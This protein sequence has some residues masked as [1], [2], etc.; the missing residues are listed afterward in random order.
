MWILQRL[1]SALSYLHYLGIIHC[2]IKPAN[3]ILHTQEHNA[4]L[5]DFGLCVLDPTADTL[6]K[7]GT[8]FYVPP[9]FVLGLPPIPASD[10]YSLGKTA[11]FLA[12]GD[13]RT[14]TAPADM[15]DPLRKLL[16]SMTLQDSLARPGDARKLHQQLTDIRRQV[17]GRT[18]TREEFKLR[19]QH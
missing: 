13:P 18:E 9:E 8:E 1:L 11:V 10:I 16:R 12:G 3:I 19:N 7:G 2:D 14:G 4:V 5:V 17:Y 15:C 6:A